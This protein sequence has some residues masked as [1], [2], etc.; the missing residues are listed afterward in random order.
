MADDQAAVTLTELRHR[1]NEIPGGLARATL[2]PSVES[3]D[4]YRVKDNP[5]NGKGGVDEG[6]EELA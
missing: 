1:P 4:A 5:V 6:E 2:F 3:P